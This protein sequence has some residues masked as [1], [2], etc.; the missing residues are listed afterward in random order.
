MKKRKIEIKRDAQVVSVSKS[1]EEGYK[2]KTM[3]NSHSFDTY[4]GFETKPTIRGKEVTKGDFV[5]KGQVIR[6]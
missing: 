3:V 5:S 1:K 6:G 4:V 2:V